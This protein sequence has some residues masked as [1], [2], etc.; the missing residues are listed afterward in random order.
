MA[1]QVIISDNVLTIILEDTF[2]YRCREVTVQIPL[3]GRHSREGGNPVTS[4]H[5]SPLSRG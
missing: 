5:G 1:I 4:K 3:C 2:D